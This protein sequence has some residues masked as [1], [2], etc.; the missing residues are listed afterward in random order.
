MD[1]DEL[2]RLEAAANEVSDSSESDSNDEDEDDGELFSNYSSKIIIDSGQS[3]KVELPFSSK[4]HSPVIDT[5]DDIGVVDEKPNIDPVSPESAEIESIAAN[6]E[7]LDETEHDFDTDDDVSVVDEKPSIIP[8]SPKS[9]DEVESITATRENIGITELGIPVKTGTGK[10][11]SDDSFGM[12]TIDTLL[13]QNKEH[14]SKK[15][16]VVNTSFSDLFTSIENAHPTAVLE[17]IEDDYNDDGDRIEDI[18]EENGQVILN[19]EE[20]QEEE[21]INYKMENSQEEEDNMEDDSDSS[22][23]EDEEYTK[24]FET[25]NELA[26][27]Y[28]DHLTHLLSCLQGQLERNLIRQKEVETEIHDM[29]VVKV[30][31]VMAPRVQ[32]VSVT[33][34]ALTIFGYPYFKDRSMYHPP[35]N[36][37]TKTKEA[38]RELDVWIDNPR[39]FSKEDKN[40]LKQCVR[41]DAIKRRLAKLEE[42]K[43]L[44][45]HHMRAIGVNDADKSRLGE[46]LRLLEL[47][48]RQ[49]RG[50]PDSDLFSDRFQAHDWEKISVVDFQSCHSPGDCE[51][52]WRN[53]LH[54]DINRGVWSK[55]EDQ[56]LRRLG[57]ATRCQDWDEIARELATGR[58]PHQ[59]IVR[60]MTR[61]NVA[62]NNRRWEK[63]ED[64]RLRRLVA[65][66][67]INDFIPWAK[68]S[69]YM[70]RRTKDQCYQRFVYSLKDSIRK[71]IYTDAEDMI[72]IIGHELY[73]N[74]WAK[75]CEMLP[76]RTPVQ[77]HCRFNSFIRP[78]FRAW[79]QDEDHLLLELVRKHGLRDWV[80]IAKDLKDLYDFDRTRHQARQ[81]FQYIYK[82]FKKSPLMALENIVYTDDPG[83]AKKRQDHI[84]ERLNT[85]YEEWRNMEKSYQNSHR[86]QQGRYAGSG[87]IELPNGQVVSN[88][89]LNNFI[90]YIQTFLPE[91]EP[92]KPLAP[93]EAASKRTLPGHEE[94]VFKRPLINRRRG[95]N[96]SAESSK[97]KRR[98]KRMNNRD[99]FGSNYITHMDKE[100]AKFFRP[101]WV[102]KRTHLRVLYSD[103]E[104]EMMNGSAQLISKILNMSQLRWNKGLN[105]QEPEISRKELQLFES[106]Q[107]L[108]K[109]ASGNIR[110]RLPQSVQI[111]GSNATPRVRRTYGKAGAVNQI[112]SSPSTNCDT[113]STDSRFDLLPPNHSTMMG[114]R[115][116]LLRNQYLQV[117]S[118]V[119]RNIREERDYVDS[120]VG[121]GVSDPDIARHVEGTG[122]FIKSDRH[123]EADRK[124]VT[125]FLQMF[126]WPA[127]M[128]ASAP[129]K[130]EKLFEDDEVVVPEVDIDSML[131]KPVQVKETRPVQQFDDSARR[132]RRGRGLQPPP[133]ARRDYNWE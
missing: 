71:G 21:S 77:L 106:V 15:E 19:H 117:D 123:L 39:P 47:K 79:T 86:E 122:T 17:T 118:E 128:S 44:V 111:V 100:I 120:V 46:R 105:I 7:D 66:C 8:V 95:W 88:K 81:R 18:A 57:E 87:H 16:M 94:E 99:R 2:A 23:S 97:R 54:P 33:K 98:R 40:K 31:R 61:H 38:N 50:L 24:D 102:V 110:S 78:E 70:D 133:K 114:F 126:Y 60:F 127:K 30:N 113:A 65:H 37:D 22:S 67:R 27:N 14:E 11:T 92:A 25:A 10:S 91:P 103:Q 116:V 32:H 112:S 13:V 42:E 83:I 131:A 36:M 51:L 89:D 64:E 43:N 59:C 41:E 125:R 76:C 52:Q 82:T 49:I 63:C 1:V 73:G 84:Y 3:S 80:S 34:R 101:T 9:S 48:E 130:Q 6:N 121:M 75:I 45:N 90:R 96:K 93:L 72:L 26:D 74:D 4:E 129:P 85:C 12:P 55:E 56:L 68:V 107:A 62:L 28:L 5:D 132:K 35:P 119:S 115:G 29:E 124:L 109:D 104:M 53:L 20:T 58:T 69:Y 108:P